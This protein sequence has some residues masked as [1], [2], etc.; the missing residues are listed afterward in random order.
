ML[1]HCPEHCEER[2]RLGAFILD[3]LRENHFLPRI[4]PLIGDDIEDEEKMQFLT[5]CSVMPKVIE[6]TQIYGEIVHQLCFKISRT[7]CRSIHVARS[8]KL[9]RYSRD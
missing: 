6:A 3:M 4:V 8:K 5:D 7:W 2:R 1:L 9:G